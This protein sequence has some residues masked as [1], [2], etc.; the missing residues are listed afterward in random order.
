MDREHSHLII[1]DDPFHREIEMASLEAILAFDCFC[2]T[3]F[4]F[5]YKYDD[6]DKIYIDAE[7]IGC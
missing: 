3:Y 6:V 4:P 1:V 7:T 5:L 2:S